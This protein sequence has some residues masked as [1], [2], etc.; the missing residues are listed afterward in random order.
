MALFGIPFHNIVGLT[1]GALILAVGTFAL[2]AKPRSTMRRLFFLLTL[3][4]GLSTV[5]FHLYS[6]PVGEIWY[7]RFRWLYWYHFI[8]FV[9][10]LWTF[11]IVFP[12]SPWSRRTTHIV[13]G[14][15]GTATAF[16]VLA[17]LL[18]SMLIWRPDQASP[19]PLGTLVN[20]AFL[21]VVPFFVARLVGD[22]REDVSESRRT[23]AGYVFAAMALAF[24]S[25]ATTVTVNAFAA[26]PVVRF[27]NPEPTV[28]LFYWVAAVST[29]AL[30]FHAVRLAMHTDGWSPVVRRFVILCY[31][32][33]VLVT[34]TSVVF[35]TNEGTAL[36]RT[37]ALLMYPLVLAFAMFRYELFDI[38]RHVRRAATITMTVGAAVFIFVLAQ[39]Y[40]ENIIQDLVF[41]NVFSGFAASALAAVAA[42]VLGVPIT[43]AAR[44]VG[45]RMIPELGQDEIHRRKLEI[46]RHG[47]EGALA[48]GLLTERESRTLIALRSSMGITDDEHEMVLRDVRAVVG[49]R[50]ADAPA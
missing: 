36:L 23:Q 48:D 27:F 22:L 31:A 38:D 18:Q 16:L 7:A 35:P 49:T 43:R 17:Y 25:G 26:E 9:A 8:L 44:A 15:L 33:L 12:R 37:L 42:T 34:A 1:A 29:L 11:A 39:N 2:V 3:V 13:I 46:Y 24:G 41:S 40:M 5:F 4:D 14:G 45:R 50:T 6:L 30:L 32:G 28:S 21:A 47:L 19:E 10:T 20:T